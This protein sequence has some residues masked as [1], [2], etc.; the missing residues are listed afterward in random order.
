MFYREYNKLVCV[1]QAEFGTSCL[2]LSPFGPAL[3]VR[4]LRRGVRRWAFGALNRRF[5]EGTAAVQQEGDGSLV[6]QGH[7]HLRAEDAVLH[8]DSLRGQRGAERLI[9]RFGQGA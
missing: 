1:C 5:S 9:E 6:D 7:V 2:A 3:G 8:G 4:R